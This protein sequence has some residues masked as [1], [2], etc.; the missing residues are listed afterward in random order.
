LRVGYLNVKRANPNARVSFPATSYWADTLL[1]RSHYYDR[2]L[3]IL[4]SDPTAAANNYYHDAVSVN[5]YYRADDLYRVFGLFKDMQ[6]RHSIDKSIWLTETN[7]MP[8][9]DR[10]IP[11]W[12]RHAT[13]SPWP[14]TQEQ[15]GAFAMQAYAVAASAGYERVSWWRLVDGNTCRQVGVW[16]AIRDDR[17]WRPAAEALRTVGTYFSNF[18]TA[19][20]LPAERHARVVFE[21]P[22]G[23]RVTALWNTS[24]RVAD[25]TLPLAGARV[26]AVDMRGQPHPVNVGNGVWHVRLAEATARFPGDPP[27]YHYIGGPPVIIVEDGVS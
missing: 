4:S 8:Q 10:V 11:C 23:Q 6:Y 16:G 15:Q 13:S 21:R 18:L 27:G 22:G 12:E 17:S 2:I 1:G 25:V 9:D 20:Y 14:T 5:I 3:D 19:T 24:G 26:Y 7:S